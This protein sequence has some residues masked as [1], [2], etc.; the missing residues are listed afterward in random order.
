[1]AKLTCS[2]GAVYAIE[3]ERTLMPNTDALACEVC[4]QTLESWQQSNVYLFATL[5]QRSQEQ[6]LIP[7]LAFGPEPKWP[8]VGAETEGQ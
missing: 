4:G 8:G 5:I 1:M 2:C 7:R 6:S 3:A